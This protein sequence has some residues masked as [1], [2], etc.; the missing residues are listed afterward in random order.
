VAFSSDVDFL[1]WVNLFK[2]IR[3]TPT[4]SVHQNGDTEMNRSTHPDPVSLDALPPET[5]PRDLAG[6]L[7]SRMQAQRDR[8]SRELIQ[9]FLASPETKS[10]T[11][12]DVLN[13]INADP[14][15]AEMWLSL[16]W[17]DVL[18]MGR[19]GRSP[20]TPRPTGSTTSMG[21]TADRIV[22][23]IRS[24]PGVMRKDIVSALNLNPDNVSGHLGKLKK[25]G[26]VRGEKQGGENSK[27]ERY[28]VD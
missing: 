17:G 20:S 12:R 18:E 10:L 8:L 19:G 25:D 21:V 22:D 5:V 3:E 7:E 13:A 4:K 9:E 11:V 6:T 24:N 23:Y 2:L 14:S 15:L 27:Q 16:D 28:Y 1:E 26:R